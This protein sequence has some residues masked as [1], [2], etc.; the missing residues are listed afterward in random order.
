MT[1]EL[2]LPPAYTASP[3]IREGETTLELGPR[4]PFQQPAAAPGR[5]QPLFPPQSWGM[6]SPQF[7]GGSNWSSFPGHLHRSGLAPPPQHPVQRSQST[8]IR[9]PNA[10]SDFARDFYAVGADDSGLYGGSSSQ[11][12]NGSAGTSPTSPSTNYP[13]SP[14]SPG[15]APPHSLSP[16]SGK[17]GA[18]PSS[19]SNDVPD[20]GRPTDRPVPGHPLLRH[21]RVLVYPNGFECQKCEYNVCVSACGGEE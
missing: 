20:D 7:T 12:Q 1:E 14:A 6:T 8:R 18:H 4:R 19:S 5:H 17:S 9:P 10:V 15:Y 16:N 11:Y 21:G 3:N 13:A 2:E